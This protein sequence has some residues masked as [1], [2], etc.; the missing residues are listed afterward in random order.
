M[1]GCIIGAAV[2]SNVWESWQGNLQC[3]A[4]VECVFWGGF[5]RF[6]YVGLFFFVLIS[7]LVFLS[8]IKNGTKS[9][10]R[11]YLRIGLFGLGI[12]I[13]GSL[14]FLNS[15]FMSRGKLLIVSDI[16]VAKGIS[17]EIFEID[18]V[19]Q[20]QREWYLSGRRG[21]QCT[22]VIKI[23]LKNDT[24]YELNFGSNPQSLEDYFTRLGFSIAN[25]TRTGNNRLC[26]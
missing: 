11:Q 19:A 23:L 14:L 20:V 5:W 17:R 18:E 22:A 12:Y 9:I 13:F 8:L 2:N 15:Y 6:F 1:I 26:Y 10:S 24:S 4:T 16:S 25:I 21:D 7:S 3:G